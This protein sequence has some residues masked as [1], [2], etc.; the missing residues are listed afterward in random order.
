MLVNCTRMHCFPSQMRVIFHITLCS[1][2][3]NGASCNNF[4][5]LFFWNMIL[6]HRVMDPGI[7]RP[8]IQGSKCSRNFLNISNL[9]DLYKSLSQ[10]T[11]IQLHEGIVS[12]PSWTKSSATLRWLTIHI[13]S[14]T[15]VKTSRC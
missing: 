13:F 11:W 14:Y 7:A 12:Y 15:A 2:N 1:E 10:N 3:T 5:I 9:A 6:H 8:H 4:R